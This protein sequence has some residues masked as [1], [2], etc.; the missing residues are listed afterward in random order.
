MLTAFE[1]QSKPTQRLN[2]R[3]AS[4]NG[5]PSQGA[6]MQPNGAFF[7]AKWAGAA[8]NRGATSE[9]VRVLYCTR[10]LGLKV[11]VRTSLSLPRAPRARPLWLTSIPPAFPVVMTTLLAARTRRWVSAFITPFQVSFPS[12]VRET[13]AGS[14]ALITTTNV[15]S[16]EGV[17]LR[18][19][20]DDEEDAAAGVKPPAG[21][22]EGVAPACAGAGSATFS[23]VAAAGAA[24]LPGVSAWRARFLA[25]RTTSTA[26]SA[27][28]ANNRGRDDRLG[29][30]SR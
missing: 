23:L 10:P 17:M 25:Q 5:L 27:R 18:A 7:A 6:E 9:L 3:L 15:R 2:S 14:L 11:R 26:S 12:A 16:G 8:P 22:T 19:G 1:G 28:T 29:F 20:R 24:A 4:S 30:S 21:V 13:Q